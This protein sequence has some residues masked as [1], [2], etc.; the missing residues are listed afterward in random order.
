M[1]HSGNGLPGAHP[2][3]Q[4]L[5][6]ICCIVFA[7]I[8]PIIDSVY[9]MRVPPVFM[10]LGQIIAWVGAGLA[11]IVTVLKFLEVKIRWSDLLPAKKKKR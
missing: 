1:S 5:L 2:F 3:V 11:G 7:R 10:D 4:F 6:A 8:A 9:T